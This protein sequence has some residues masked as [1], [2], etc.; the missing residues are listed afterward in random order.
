M[1]I[2][3]LNGYELTCVLTNNL[4]QPGFAE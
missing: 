2:V 1:G 4:N 3:N